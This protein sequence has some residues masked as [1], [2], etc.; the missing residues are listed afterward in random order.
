MK[1]NILIVFLFFFCF[2]W[3]TTFQL[4]HEYSVLRTSN[5]TETNTTN[6]SKTILKRFYIKKQN[7]HISQSEIPKEVENNGKKTIDLEKTNK[8]TLS[9]DKDEKFQH[10]LMLH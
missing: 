8:I 10:Q 4:K 6:S 3:V 2:S 9:F 5:E 1:S 7:T